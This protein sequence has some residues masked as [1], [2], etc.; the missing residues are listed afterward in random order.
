MLKWTTSRVHSA[1]VLATP[2]SRLHVHLDVPMLQLTT[3]SG[4][5]N[6]LATPISRLHFHLDVPVLQ[7]TTSSVLH[8]QLET[9]VSRLHVLLTCRYAKMDHLTCPRPSVLA[10]PNE[11]NP[12]PQNNPATTMLQLTTSSGLHTSAIYTPSIA[13]RHLPAKNGS[14]KPVLGV[15]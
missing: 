4:L 8:T 6:H 11:S 14:S 12:R 1:S 9:P 13:F 7:L 3:S 2:V 10:T 5:H 15:C